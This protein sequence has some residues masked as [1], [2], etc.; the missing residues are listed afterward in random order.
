MTTQ[1]DKLNMLMMQ[2]VPAQNQAIDDGNQGEAEELQA[3]MDELMMEIDRED[4]FS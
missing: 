4:E 2:L 3:R 1:L